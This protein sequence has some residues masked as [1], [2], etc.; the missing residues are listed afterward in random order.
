[1]ISENLK[2]YANNAHDVFERSQTDGDDNSYQEVLGVKIFLKRLSK[3]LSKFIKKRTRVLKMKKSINYAYKLL[4][5][6]I[7]R[8]MLFEHC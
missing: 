3:A 5:L 7:P 8:K 2:V 4:S 1:M 6:K